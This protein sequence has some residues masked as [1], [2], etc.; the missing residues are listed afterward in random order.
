MPCYA[1]RGVEITKFCLMRE[2]WERFMKENMLQN[3][4]KAKPSLHLC[5]YC[6]SSINENTENMPLLTCFKSLW[7]EKRSVWL[8]SVSFLI[9]CSQFPR[10]MGKYGWNMHGVGMFSLRSHFDS[11]QRQKYRNYF[12][13]LYLKSHF[14]KSCRLFFSDIKHTIVHIS[15]PQK[16]PP[17][18]CKRDQAFL[19][20]KGSSSLWQT[21]SHQAWVTVAGL[22]FFLETEKRSGNLHGSQ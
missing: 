8:E 19:F 9:M 17:N 5:F 15:D 21:G 2:G 20:C 12:N 22:T 3:S 16:K 6:V 4:S 13:I 1:F 18:S 11:V 7:G 10:A 14:K